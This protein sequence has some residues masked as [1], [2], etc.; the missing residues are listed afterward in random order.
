MKQHIGF[1]LKHRDHDYHPATRMLFAFK[2]EST[3]RKA[4]ADSKLNI[5][6]LK[7]VPLFIE[8]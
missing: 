7:I 6:D 2:D 3:A 8:G 1:V 4:I 5:A